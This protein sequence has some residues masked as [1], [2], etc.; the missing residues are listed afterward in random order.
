[1]EAK[2]SLISNFEVV[3]EDL[4][5]AVD[6]CIGEKHNSIELKYV[7]AYSAATIHAMLDYVD[8]YI[9][10]DESVLAFKYVNNSI[11]HVKGFVTHSTLGGIVVLT[12][13]SPEDEYNS[14]LGNGYSY[15]EP[16]SI[17][18]VDANK[19]GYYKV[20]NRK[21]YATQKNISV[22]QAVSQEDV[23]PADS[24]SSNAD[25]DNGNFKVK[26]PKTGDYFLSWFFNILGV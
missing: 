14:Y 21:C 24:N 2:E 15:S 19:L 17:E 22:V 16:L 4:N 3:Y 9:K 18:E 13:N 12:N 7:N 6:E 20:D 8:R 26:P 11:K 5:K 23:V 10:D 1:M 25:A